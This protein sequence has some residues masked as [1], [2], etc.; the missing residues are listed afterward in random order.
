MIR[1]MRSLSVYS[2]HFFVI[3]PYLTLSSWMYC[4]YHCDH[5]LLAASIRTEGKASQVFRVED[6]GSHPSFLFIVLWHAQGG[7]QASQHPHTLSAIHYLRLSF[8]DFMVWFSV[9]LF[10]CC[11]LCYPIELRL[12]CF[13]VGGRRMPQWF[14]TTMSTKVS[15]TCSSKSGRSILS[16]FHLILTFWS[17]S[18]STLQVLLTHA[19]HLGQGP[20]WDLVPM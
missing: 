8:P 15:L 12:Q 11:S 17:H 1:K 6:W 4:F 10:S 2:F 13:S 14:V 16:S 7:A 9:S 20:S 18:A 19:C 5:A 3:N